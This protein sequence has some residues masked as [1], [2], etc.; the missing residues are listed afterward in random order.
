M[1]SH[2]LDSLFVNKRGEHSVSESTNRNTLSTI[3]KVLRTKSTGIIRTKDEEFLTCK[4]VDV[5][6]GIDGLWNTVNLVGNYLEHQLVH[7]D[8]T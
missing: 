2:H 8:I 1:L 5:V 6:G 3:P 4:E 7:T